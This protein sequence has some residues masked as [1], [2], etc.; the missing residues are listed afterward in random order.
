[1]I[2]L[3][4]YFS[5][6]E[7]DCQPEK[8]KMVVFLLIRVQSKPKQGQERLGSY[9]RR[10]TLQAEKINDACFWIRLK[11]AAEMIGAFQ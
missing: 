6:I 2:F 8:G 3:F 4:A 10:S 11:R 7:R 5:G 1:M 9:G